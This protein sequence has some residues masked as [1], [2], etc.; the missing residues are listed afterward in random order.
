VASLINPKSLPLPG[1][2]HTNV[3]LLEAVE[4]MEG[5][6]ASGRMDFLLMSVERYLTNLVILQYFLALVPPRK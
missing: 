1:A 5:K 6:V 2:T 4:A 3:G